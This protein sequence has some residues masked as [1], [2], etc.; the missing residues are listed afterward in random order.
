MQLLMPEAAYTRVASRLAAIRPDL[1]VVTLDATGAFAKAGQAIAADAIDP[2]VFWISADLFRTRQFDSFTKL[3]QTARNG[4]WV[5]VFLAGI[6]SPAFQAIMENG[7]RLTKSSAQAPAIAEYVMCQALSL[8]HPIAAQQASQAARQWQRHNFREIGSTSWLILGGGAI[9]TQIAARLQPFGA[10]LTI[11]RR[12]QAPG[13]AGSVVRPTEDLLFC[14][15]Q[16]DVV[17]LA[18]ALNASTR[19]I[20]NNAF[21]Q[22]MKPGSL[23]INI[24]RGALI[25]DA[26]LQAGLD[27]EAPLHACLDV[28]QTEPLPPDNWVWAHPRVRVT[29]HCSNAGDGV[30]A[31]GDQLFLD[32][33]ERYLAGA[34][35]LNEA[36]IQ[37]TY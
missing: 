15:P 26:A 22:A 9:A 5:Q 30:A 10:Q 33:L 32:N 6:D 36:D 3:V 12:K 28:F 18:C 7:V 34:P 27:R 17:V 14:L 20:A 25:D 21:F 19:G 1:D 8:L 31:R 24:A 35:L 4:R 23:L 29:A 2:E 16:A 13:P 11:L 37:E